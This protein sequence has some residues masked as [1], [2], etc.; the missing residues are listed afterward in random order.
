M[1]DT[2]LSPPDP[3]RCCEEA[4]QLQIAGKL[5]AAERLYRLVLDTQSSHAIANHCLGMLM[6]QTRR[7]TKAVAHLLAALEA[8]PEEPAYWLGYLE[9]LLQA[10]RIEEAE[11]AATLG[12]Q[13][14]LAGN[15]FDDLRLRLAA[16]LDRRAGAQERE[17]A[18]L[19]GQRRFAE[20]LRRSRAL[21][22]RFPA[23][24][25]AWKIQ[26]SI[27]WAQDEP[28]AA[29]EALQRAASLLPQDAEAHS[30]LGQCLAQR[31]RFAE[32]EEALRRAVAIDPRFAGAHF[33]LSMAYEMQGRF[34]DAEAA[35][36]TALS[37]R[38]GHLSDD[39]ERGLS[40]LLYLASHDPDKDAD[41]LFAEHCRVGEI[42][43]APWRGLT[44]HYP[45]DR[46]P[47]RRLQV[48]FVSGDFRDHAVATF[49]EPVLS[50]LCRLSSLELH[51]YSN[52]WADDR[53]TRRLRSRFHH[54]RSVPAL[55]DETLAAQVR[56]DG[57]DVLIDLSGH[58]AHNRLRLFARKP[59]PLQVSWLGYPGTTGLRAM[60]YYLTDR[61][62]LPP[63]QFDR[64]FT[65]KLVY[66]HAFAPFK[67]VETAP[68]VNALPALARGSLQLASFNRPGKLNDAT[69]ALWSALLRALPE[70]NLLLGGIDDEDV[71]AQL[72]RRLKALGIGSGRLSFEPRCTLDHYLAL[73]HRVDLCLDPT[74]YTGGTTTSHALW[75][76]VPTLTL[77]GATP[78]SRQGASIQ[79]LL[80][81]NAFVAKDAADFVAK[82]VAWSKNLDEL[83][84]VR[85]GLRQRWE[86][87]PGRE[88]AL[89]AGCLERALRCMWQ[90]WCLGQAPESF[91][92]A[93]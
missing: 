63:G 82:G 38:G 86:R 47:T 53:V 27:L 6:L 13:H 21:T 61:H 83:A 8:R 37:L 10:G 3:A 58:T 60:D 68:P 1:F 77:S 42:L 44:P 54:W 46:D 49:F 72:M 20:A 16:E 23:R 76:G 55:S 30:N 88:P 65:E 33:R 69:L 50:A 22:A 93:P 15:A 75:M 43:E 56:A 85:A 89:T 41:A 39:D 32:A 7:A 78:A 92:I 34:K 66:L 80:G 24:G 62:F 90:R 91:E 14:G 4:I 9:A 48:G 11:A 36:R 70:A 45:Q 59:A 18:E 79:E 52:S 12:E 35:L 2:T 19:I 5:E 71:R 17:L 84:A 29:L 25:L 74:P 40:N 26:G 81:L 51:G 67:V 31:R 73:H 64:H 28:Y 87:A 57:I